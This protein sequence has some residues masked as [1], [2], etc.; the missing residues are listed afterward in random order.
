MFTDRIETWSK[1]KISNAETFTSST[2]TTQ[3][4]VTTVRCHAALI[5]DLLND[6]YAF[7]LTAR[8]QSDLLSEKMVN[9]QQV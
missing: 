6:D 1:S 3:A 2:Q 9:L 5:E 8:F 4:V 7:V